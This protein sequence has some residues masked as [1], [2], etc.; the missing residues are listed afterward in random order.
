MSK[1]YEITDVENV[2][3]QKLWG[4]TTLLVHNQHI[5]MSLISIV[6]GGYCSKHLHE[7]KTN[8]FVVLSGCLLVTVYDA[9][10][11]E[12]T[13]LVESGGCL[14]VDAK[15]KHRFEAM[16]PTSAMEVYYPVVGPVLLDDIVRDDV[17]GIR[18]Q[19]TN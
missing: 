17:G 12:S 4:E 5:E 13:S 1:T 14:G 18:D 19:A 7:Y 9:D 11:R 10:G 8:I 6:R 2:P 16:A 15:L 3:K